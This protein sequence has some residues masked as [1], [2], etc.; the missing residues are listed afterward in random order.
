M[1]V[2]NFMRFKQRSGTY[3]TWAAQNFFAGELKEYSGISY[4]SIPIA[5]A[6]NASTRGGDRAEAAISGPVEQL[7]LNVFAEAAEKDWLLEIKTVK[8]N[9]ATFALDAL[10]S[11][12][13]WACSQVQYDSSQNGV[14]LQLASPLDS[15]TQIGGRFLS[16]SLVG[17]LPSS[18]T[19]SLQ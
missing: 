13:I 17:A 5:V 6:T 18:G 3:T 4:R 16:Q 14:V 19:L 9:R 1:E 11:S 15:V 2:C 12:E 7:T 10:L 8:I